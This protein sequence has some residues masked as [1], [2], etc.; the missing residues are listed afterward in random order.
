MI[1]LAC[2][3]GAPTTAQSEPS[4]TRPATA[5]EAAP[6]LS[7]TLTYDPSISSPFTGRV[8][9]MFAADDGSRREPRLGPAW[10]GTQP[11]FAK[12][13]VDWKP[14]QPLV[15]DDAALSFPKKLSELQPGNYQVQAVMRRNLD[16]PNIGTGA[17]SAYSS[18]VS[19]SGI[20]D[21]ADAAAT[22][23]G[24]VPL[25]ID[26]LVEP[27]TFIG[28][29]RIELVEL[30]SEL[31]SDFHNR[32][33]I[34][35]AAVIMP[36]GLQLEPER[37]YPAVYW[38]GGFGSDHHTARFKARSWERTGYDDRFFRIILDP[39]CYGGH[40]VFADSA[41]NGPRGRALV[42]EFIPYLERTFRLVSA[43]TARFVSGHSSGGWSSLWLQ[44]RYP[45]FFGGTWSLAPD[46]VDFR[47]FQRINLYESGANMYIDKANNRRPIA[48]ARDNV[49]AW[50]DSFAK[51][52]VVQGE[53]GQL[54]SFEWVFSDRDDDRL[55]KPLYD[56]ESG[57]VNP[58]VAETWKRY[59][60]R[61]LLEQNW[62]TLGPKLDDGREIHVFMGDSD[63]F[64]LE[65]ATQLLKQSQEKLG[66]K[67]VIEIIPGGDHGTIDTAKLRQRIDRE[68]LLIF[69]ANHPEHARPLA[70]D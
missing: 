15:I 46:P 66:S 33:V 37:R 30:R 38:I 2:C 3:F 52:E 54:R 26:Q 69:N 70:Y 22:K 8:Y 56:R 9:V 63:T 42:E 31:L 60:I 1:L 51:M 13:V 48:R 45:D 6:P 20:D 41:N 55:P 67:A 58:Q 53:G 21:G 44:V 36:A 43:P 7:F 28:T 61:L 16:S 62:P 12:D 29:D 27:R 10:F 23:W 49:L 59:D 57:L 19:V 65:G 50:Y 11:F 14:D 25:R 4:S 5:P 47:D 35:R 18:A 32:D 64:Y 17:G 68:M 40:H 34:M 24:E 39:S